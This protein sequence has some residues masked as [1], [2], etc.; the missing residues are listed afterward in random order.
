[1]KNSIFHKFHNNDETIPN[2]DELVKVYLKTM[3]IAVNS[4]ASK[5]SV[6]SHVSYLMPCSNFLS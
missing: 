3:K 1:M 5:P 6:M 2:L 4:F